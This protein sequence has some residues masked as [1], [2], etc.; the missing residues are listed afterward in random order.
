MGKM[1]VIREKRGLIMT[2]A[3][4]FDKLLRILEKKQELLNQILE[5]TKQQGDTFNSQ[6]IGDLEEII[7]QKQK[8]IQKI[9]DLDDE[10]TLHFNGLKQIMNIEKLEEVSSFGTSEAPQLKGAVQKTIDTVE[11]I[12]K[13]E[14]ENAKKAKALLDNLSDEI[15]KISNIK[16]VSLAYGPKAGE[17]HSSFFVDKKS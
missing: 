16:R 4:C 13:F 2:T 15:N 5:L 8:R 12:S 1:N 17:G 11:I 6:R 7:A 3:E 9:D 14:K 10:F